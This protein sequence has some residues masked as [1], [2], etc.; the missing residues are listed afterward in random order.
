MNV[1]PLSKIR[2]IN[3]LK[4]WLK[5]VSLPR[6]CLVKKL[7]NVLLEDIESYPSCV[8]WASF[9][10]NMLESYGLGNIWLFQ[11]N[12]SLNDK[13]TLSIFKERLM[14]MNIQNLNEQIT[15]VSKNRLYRTLNEA[16]IINNKYLYDIKE[17]Y[18]R[19]SISKFRL[20]THNLMIE[21]GRWTS[22]ELI[23]RE[24][25]LCGKLEDE[26]HAVIECPRYKKYR[27]MYI[28][29]YLLIRP[30]MFKFI[31]FLNTDNTDE[32]KSFGK[33]CHSL[34]KYYEAN[35]L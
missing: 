22:K 32:I 9:V 7:Y 28:P 17:K 13:S 19:I 21:R 35:V 4:Y 20:G 23:D 16:T 25:N 24:C 1:L 31:Q 15:N 34:F 2:H 10:K 27:K 11:N 29:Q 3:I 33:F 14:D 12:V 18:I 30:N 26:Y 5:I 6:T 8:N